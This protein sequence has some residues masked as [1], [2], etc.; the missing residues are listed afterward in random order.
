[1]LLINLWMQFLFIGMVAFGGGTAMIPVL[2]RVIV[3]DQGWLTLSEF[4]D[5]IG[6]SQMTPGPIA[7]N[8]A[9]FIGFRTVF[10]ETASY[11]QAFIGGSVATFGLLVAPLTLMT[12]VLYF[13][14]NKS[15]QKQLNRLLIGLKPALVGLIVASAV[16]I[17]QTV[18]G[19]LLHGGVL[20]FVVAGVMQTKIH[21]IFYIL[22]AGLIGVFVL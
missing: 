21:P 2:Q 22:A 13:E 3:N 16:S 20:L 4:A 17:G 12:L 10:M 8:A 15:I 9:T 6:L 14:Q 7:I 1:M 19:T 5:I 18:E 11:L